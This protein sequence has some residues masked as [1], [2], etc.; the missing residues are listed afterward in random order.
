MKRTWLHWG[1]SEALPALILVLAGFLPGYQVNAQDGEPFM[2]HFKLE[3]VPGNRITSIS[4]DLENAMIFSGISGVITFDSEEWQIHSVPNIPLVIVKDSR[5]PLVYVGGR[6]FYGYLLKTDTGAYEYHNLALEEE[7]TGDIYRIYQTSSHVIFYG[8]E[9]IAMAD[10]TELYNLKRFRPDSINVFSGLLIYRNNAYVN[11]LGQGIHEFGDSGFTSI[12]TRVDFSGSEILFGIEYGDSSALLGLDN[13]SL[14]WSDGDDFTRVELEDQEYLDESFLEDAAWLEKNIFALSTVLGGCML[15]DVVSGKTINILNNQT[16]LP[17]DEIYAIGK[18]NNHGLWLSHQYGLTRVDVRLPIRSFE[19]YP[20]L[21]GNLTAVAILDSTIYV[22]TNEGIF[23]LEEKKDYLEEEVVIRLTIP[24]TPRPRTPE[25]E[26]EQE[27]E[28]ELQDPGEE[29]QEEKQLS[30]KERRK[31][32]REAKKAAKNQKEETEEDV[33]VTEEPDETQAVEDSLVEEEPRGLKA[34]FQKRSGK[35]EESVKE[36]DEKEEE[37]PQTPVARTRYIK[38]KIYSLQSISH[39]FTR[40]GEFEE[41]AKDLMPVGNRILIATNEGLYE[42]VDKK[43]KIIREG[44]YVE[45]IFPVADPGRIYVV[46]DESAYQLV[47]EEDSWRTSMDFSY[48]GEEIHSVC[49]E[50]DSI[51]WL[52]CDNRSYRIRPLNDSV[53]DIES[54]DFHE[55]YFDPVTMRNIRDT[56]Y[57]FLSG[58]IYYHANDSIYLS[59]TFEERALL[60][61][62][63]STC[64]IAW[65]QTGDRWISF[66]NQENY[67]DKM[68][69][70]LNLFADIED[71][72]L[73]MDGNVWVVSENT[74]LHKINRDKVDAYDP[75]FR[76]FLKSVYNDDKQYLLDELQFDYYD[77]SLIFNL[78]AP[79][80]LRDNST[81]YQYFAEGMSDGWS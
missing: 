25:P 47:L 61:I 52:G 43:L 17:D 68:N 56:V 9:L 14:F 3:N 57:F 6:G 7:E 35:S 4:Q 63:L 24:A 5:L 64:A 2:N 12:E 65:V 48:V 76:L 70:Y 74:Y 62:Y 10:R 26:V 51:I 33:P 75:G 18:D 20:G 53:S 27:R 49:E 36:E 54:F 23:Y 34:L 16:G 15:V 41:K 72:F 55:K 13:N 73:D 28:S 19:N 39:E 21:E 59:R 60:K 67:N 1:I 69:S 71:L 81:S 78:S 42:I 29:V 66:W 8:D 79:F 11:L 44:W 30:A 45:N 32:R 77:R 31:L 80:Y 58:G 37:I 50:K 22:S 46:T 38:Q 40:L